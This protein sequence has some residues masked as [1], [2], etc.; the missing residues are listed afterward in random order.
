MLGRWCVLFLAMKAISFAETAEVRDQSWAVITNAQVTLR[1][2]G[3]KQPI[4]I[5]STDQIG[6][7]AFSNIES[8]V[9]VIEISSPGF[10]TRMEPVRV[11]TGETQVSLLLAVA[12]IG[13]GT[14]EAGLA[15]PNVGFE[16]AG[17]ETFLEGAVVEPHN[18][19]LRTITVSL[20]NME[21]K[22]R[23]IVVQT[24]ARGQFVFRDVKPG[25]Y[26]LRA[27]R[28]GYSDFI[29][30]SIEVKLGHRTRIFDPLEMLRCPS[31][32]HCQPNRQVH[33]TAICL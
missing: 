16:P 14:C 3:T 21:R 23:P 19:R 20:R 5:A 4:Q 18:I 28:P 27:V 29:I 30:D 9:Y 31:G 17:Q 1:R 22:S 11:G 33:Q 12:P 32:M 24:D 25:I 6:R 8:G 2:T 7:C 26:Q 10:S 13:T 15:V